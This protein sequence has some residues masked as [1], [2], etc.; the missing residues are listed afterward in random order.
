MTFSELDNL[1]VSAPSTHATNA[2]LTVGN[3]VV[4]GTFYGFLIMACLAYLVNQIYGYY[5]I[6]PSDPA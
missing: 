1:F 6:K 5:A 2:T 4:L 3:N